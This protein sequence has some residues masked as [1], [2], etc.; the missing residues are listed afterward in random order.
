MGADAKERRP[1]LPRRML[2]AGGLLAAFAVVG[3]GACCCSATDSSETTP[4]GVSYAVNDL[5]TC[6][7]RGSPCCAT[8]AGLAVSSGPTASSDD[9]SSSTGERPGSFAP[10]IGASIFTRSAGSVTSASPAPP[11]G[12]A[13]SCVESGT[14]TGGG[15]GGPN[16]RQAV[17]AKINTMPKTSNHGIQRLRPATSRGS[18]STGLWMPGTLPSWRCSSDFFNAS[19]RM[20]MAYDRSAL[21]RTRRG[22]TIVGATRYISVL[23]PMMPSAFR[24]LRR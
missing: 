20:D 22:S 13:T 15:S 23:G 7:F 14:E 1:E 5:L 11:G 24:P 8:L 4:G 21:A 18:P 2:G 9:G 6:D 10:L 19:S 16:C 12:V 17:Q 3:A